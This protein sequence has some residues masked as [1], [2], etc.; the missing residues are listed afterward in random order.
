MAITSLPNPPTRSDPVNFNSR[1]DAFLSALPAFAT[2]AN[3]L[4]ADVNAKQTA[5]ATSASN[6]AAAELAANAAANVTAWVSG[7]T[8]AVGNVRYSP[9]TFLSYRRKTA[10]AG[11]TDP[12]ADSTNWQ[13]INGTGNVDLNSPQTLTNKA[14]GSGSTINGISVANLVNTYTI[15]EISGVKTFYD[16]VNLSDSGFRFYSDSSRDTGMYWIADGRIGFVANGT[17]VGEVNNVGLDMPLQPYR[18]A[19]A[20]VALGVGAVGTYA[21]LACV[22]GSGGFGPGFTLAG[23]ELRYSDADGGNGG[24]PSGTWIS[25]GVSTR[26]G[27]G[28]FKT[29]LWLRIS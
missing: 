4:Q 28:G 22:T 8:Y 16:V 1:A 29:T 21:L 6:A 2:E 9:I 10:G 14:I 26:N 7:T 15:Q 20:N 18:V 12:G 5:A 24:A 25:L 3:A 23:S 19:N 11:T 13:L 17:A 27:G